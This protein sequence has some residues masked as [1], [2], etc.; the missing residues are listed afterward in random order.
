MKKLDIMNMRS[1]ETWA[2]VNGKVQRVE[3]K[4][5]QGPV[6]KESIKEVVEVDKELKVEEVKK[7]KKT[8]KEFK[9]D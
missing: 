3:S 9:K 7:S 2:L 4:I 5:V 6:V 1:N 8:K